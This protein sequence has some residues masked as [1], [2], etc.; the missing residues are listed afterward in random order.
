[1]LMDALVWYFLQ[2]S[3]T[4]KPL[5]MYNTHRGRYT[6][7]DLRGFFVDTYMNPFASQVASL[8]VLMLRL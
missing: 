2:S 7:H 5:V 8:I 6:H 3:G 4:L 1:M